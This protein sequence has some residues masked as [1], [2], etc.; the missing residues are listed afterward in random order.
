MSA[1]YP[2]SL[3]VLEDIKECMSGTDLRS[4]FIKTL[5]S[6]MKTR[7]LHQ[8]VGTSDILTAYV[9]TIKALRVLDSSSQLL[10]AVTEPIHEYLRTRSDTIR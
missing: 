5:K 3:P 8:G 4:Y 2:D 1:E 9:A 6:E 7:L 10:D